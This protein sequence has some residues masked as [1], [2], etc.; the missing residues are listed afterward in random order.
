V[1]RNSGARL[2]TSEYILFLDA[3]VELP[4]RTL[5]KRALNTIR[6]RKLECVT[7]NV[8][9]LDGSLLDRLL[10]AANNL[11][12]RVAS[13]AKPFGTGMFLLFEKKAFD[14]LGGFNENALFAEDYL[15]TKQVPVRR[16]GIVRGHVMTSARRMRKT[17]RTRMIWLFFW[18]ML[19]TWNSSYFLRDQNYWA[20]EEQ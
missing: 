17:G 2:A 20:T 9:C 16:F 5:L 13:F 6:R 14:R 18:T 19:N 15:L 10:Y 7:T 11:V 12:Q 4:D 3:D 1:G 8:A